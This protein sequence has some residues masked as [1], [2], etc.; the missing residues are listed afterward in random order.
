M[1]PYI[2]KDSVTTHSIMRGRTAQKQLKSFS[3]GLIFQLQSSQTLLQDTNL[4]LDKKW[5]ANQEPK[6]CTVQKQKVLQ[7]TTNCNFSNCKY[8]QPFYTQFTLGFLHLK[9]LGSNSGTETL[10]SKKTNANLK[11]IFKAYESNMIKPIMYSSTTVS[12]KFYNNMLSSVNSL[13][14][15][16]PNIL[17]IRLKSTFHSKVNFYLVQDALN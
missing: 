10:Q 14:K 8:K 15:I 1:S 17:L 7:K 6:L 9:G 11:P 5:R 12:W 16:S 13:A 2:M 4:T 3:S